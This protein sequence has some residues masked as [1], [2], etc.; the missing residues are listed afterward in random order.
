MAEAFTFF[1]K[2][3]LS[4]WHRAPFT[5]GGVEFTCAE[6]FMM[7]AK[8]LLFGDHEA[9]Q[10]I[11]SAGTP[12]EQQ[13]IGRIVRGFDEAAWALFREGVVFQGNHARFAQ[14]ADQRELLF[15]TRGRPWWKRR[16]TISSGASAW[17]RTIRT[18]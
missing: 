14:K 9:A 1:W 18:R 11:L 7:H 16:R 17:Q 4:Q 15:A 10:A 13:A 12:R 5:V 2:S 6:Q 3:K 8:A